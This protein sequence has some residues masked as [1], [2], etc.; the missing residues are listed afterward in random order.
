MIGVQGA[1]AAG[2]VSSMLHIRNYYGDSTSKLARNLSACQLI[3]P[4]K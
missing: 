1:D 3:R 2:Y 4:Q